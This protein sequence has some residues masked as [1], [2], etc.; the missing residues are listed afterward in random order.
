M[1]KIHDIKI[2]K[3]SPIEVDESFVLENEKIKSPHVIDLRNRPRIRH[4]HPNALQDVKAELKKGLKSES[5]WYQEKF[6]PPFRIASRFTEMMRMAVIGVAVVFTLN[7]VGV[8]YSGIEIKED[9]ATAAYS[10]YESILATGP[11][12]DAFQEAEGIFED[13]QE[14]LWFLQNQRQELLSQNKTASA[15]TNLLT[16]GEELSEAGASFMTFVENVKSV[17]QELLTEKPGTGISVAEKL[18]STYEID[19]SSAMIN[20]VEANERVQSVSTAIFPGEIKAT[21]QKAQNELNELTNVLTQFEEIFPIVLALL[22][23]EHPQRYLVLL[24]NNHESR[25]GGGFIGSYLLIDLN[26]GY[27]DGMTFNDVY[28]IDGQF[29]SDI[30]PP[31]E[32]AKLTN[33]WRFRDSN[34]SPDMA[35]SSAKSAWFLEE[36]GGPGVDHVITVDLEFV[37][38]LLEITGPIKINE[39]PLALDQNNF[40]TLI[41]YMV[42]SKHMGE[43]TPKDVLGSFVTN[44]Q[45]KLREEQPWMEIIQ[46]MQE[47]AASKHMAAYSKSDKAQDLFNEF[48]LSG[49]IA[50]PTEGEDYFGLIHTSIGGNKTDKYITQNIEHQT[51]IEQNGTLLNQVT[52]T[53][54]HLW[55]D[56]EESRL[57]SILKSFGFSDPAP[58][59]IDIMGSAPNVSV[60]RVYVP[61][62]TRLVSTIGVDKEDVTIE[63]DEDLGLDYFYFTDSVYPGQASSFTLT[64]EPPFT[65]DLT[66][67][68]EYRL[69]VIKQPGDT[70]TTFTKTITG[71]DRL[72]H[73]RSF[74]EAFLETAHEERL[75]V[76]TYETE[77]TQDLHLAQLWGK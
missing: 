40:A 49:A 6:D 18:R 64:Y 74:P 56:L 35:V 25:P 30:E 37:S 59:V 2:Q 26:D 15:V 7:A 31:G 3:E 9:I 11:S 72:T 42:E 47:M 46:L 60:F 70:S 51:L 45:E 8:Y 73:Y 69:N 44:V 16:A 38:R 13:A 55:N 68:D 28:E 5:R 76:Y 14:S 33:N 36:E 48:G 63:Y 17:S 22:G 54:E 10:S 32:I 24:E 20:L 75:G 39:L 23:D 62:G 41:S 27:L 50:T 71:D 61:H 66:P 19:F 12:Q 65:L 43:E 58:W 67:L 53:R 21:I 34:Y 29:Y 1:A 52:L 77:L 4:E 57:R